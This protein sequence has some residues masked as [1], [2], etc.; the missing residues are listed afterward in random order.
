MSLP[1]GWEGNLVPISEAYTL[2]EDPGITFNTPIT[3]N[4]IQNYMAKINMFTISGHTFL[5]G[6]GNK[7]IQGVSLQAKG[8][9][10]WSNYTAKEFSNSEG[11]YTVDVPYGFSGLVVPS[12]EGYEF[13]P[14]NR[15]YDNLTANI[16][17]QDYIGFTNY[18]TPPTT[19]MISGYV[20]YLGVGIQGVAIVDNTNDIV[21]Y[22]NA[23]GYYSFEKQAGWTG[24]ARAVK[25]PYKFSPI[26]Y[27][28]NNLSGNQ[29]D[30]NYIRVP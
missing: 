1:Y 24:T 4:Q 22:T 6:L 19:Y 23:Q 30:K 13:T 11:D 28:Y 12:K 5:D 18:V 16:D 8:T 3:S 14:E 17:K 10:V 2:I 7:P 20:T 15:E 25:P 9:G 26:S 21:A 27:S 29:T